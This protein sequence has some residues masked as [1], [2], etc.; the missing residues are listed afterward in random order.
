MK[1]CVIPARGG[2]KR[3]PRKN[4]RSF[5]GA[6]VISYAIKAALESGVF[7][8]VVVSSDDPEIIEMAKR[9]G[10]TVPFV[11]PD[12]LSDDHTTTVEV[13][14]HCLNWF[15]SQGNIVQSLA[16]IYPVN[17]FL[18]SSLLQNAHNAWS[19]S[20][21][22]YCFSVSEFHSAPQR[23]LT[24]TAEGRISSIDDRYRNT[25]TQDLDKAYFDAGMFYF[26][27]SEALKQGLPIYSEVS[28]PYVLPRYQAHDIDT[29]D[30]WQYAEKIYKA[31]ENDF[32]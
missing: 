18:T 25:R 26:F 2:S 20:D 12:H 1:L 16:C 30:D 13:L 4:V 27:D 29:E 14:N 5:L 11:R 10:A 8:E 24:M 9:F 21:A 31:F 32:R 19:N 15:E 6:P 28:L 23:A 22:Q 17:P 3:I 7:D